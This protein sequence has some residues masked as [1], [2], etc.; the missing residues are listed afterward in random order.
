MADWEKNNAA[1]IVN[2]WAVLEPKTMVS[3][4][5][6]VLT[7]EADGSISVSGRNSNCEVTIVVETELTGITGLRLEVLA[8]KR[9]PSGG[10][11]R[12]NDGNFVLNE[13]R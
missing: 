10:P 2:R 3:S 4:N 9:L 12:A 13:P 1:S 11:G 8:D 6:S 5:K 7:K